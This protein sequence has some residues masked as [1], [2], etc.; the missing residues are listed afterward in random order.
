MTETAL[1][2]CDIFLTSLNSG[3]TL[4]F[5]AASLQIYPLKDKRI[6]KFLTQYREQGK[7]ILLDNTENQEIY[8]F[9]VNTIISVPKTIERNKV[10]TTSIMFNS[11]VLPI[12]GKCNLNCSYCFAQNETGFNFDNFTTENIVEIANFLIKQNEQNQDSQ[13]KKTSIHIIFFGGEPLLKFDIMQF[14]VK[15]FAE[16]YPLY[17]VTYSI[18][19]NGTIVNEKI[20]RFLKENNFS[21]LVSIDGLDNEFNVRK[22]KNGRSSVQRTIENI[23]KMSDRGIDI[24]L[25]ATL[26]NNVSSI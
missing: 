23:R 6:I 3:T 9:I 15:H 11:I 7:D 13:D 1:N 26:L 21:V 22:F 2:S 16:K 5:H 4:F 17:T 12:A 24:E 10:D 14:A 8:D 25:R 18:T 19:T 20:L